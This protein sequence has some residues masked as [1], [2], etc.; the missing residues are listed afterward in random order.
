LLKKF[1]QQENSISKFGHGIFIVVVTLQLLIYIRIV[2]GFN[3]LGSEITSLSAETITLRIQAAIL[4]R[5]DVVPLTN[6]GLNIDLTM[7]VDNK[8]GIRVVCK[9][10]S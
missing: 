4:I 6:V 2:L 7:L 9:Y 8:H 3:Y 5:R 10:Y 1:T